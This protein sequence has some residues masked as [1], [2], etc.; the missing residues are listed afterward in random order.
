MHQCDVLILG[1]GPSGATAALT[2]RKAYPHLSVLMIEASDVQAVRPGEILDE[3]AFP[4]LKQL[5]LVDFFKD[6]KHPVIATAG[7]DYLRRAPMRL[8]D[9]APHKGWHLDRGRFDSMLSGFAAASGTAFF[10][11]SLQG[12]QLLADG[13]WQITAQS[14]AATQTAVARLVVDATGRHARFASE[15]GIPQLTYDSM[16][17][18]VRVIA[19]DDQT[20]A[21]NYA[22]MI[23]PFEHG[24]WYSTVTWNKQLAIV[25]MTDADIGK[26][27]QLTHITRWTEQLRESP[28]TYARV[29][30]LTIRGD[31]SIRAA[32][33]RGLHNCCGDGWLAVGDAASSFDPL[34]ENGITR[35]LR[36]GMQAAHAIGAHFS[37]KANAIKHY[38]AEIQ[39][40]FETN[41][42]RRTELYRLEPHWKNAAFWM[43]RQTTPPLPS[44]AQTRKTTL[45]ISNSMAVSAETP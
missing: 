31:L 17:G 23:E 44:K 12:V 13:R 14:A 39:S 3:D 32:N 10:R 38:Q 16:I 42:K 1:A 34:T 27:L 41:L 4:I 5:A 37:G 33:T 19:F 45:S 7:D 26:R 35:S 40:E 36:L 43:R 22:P 28:Q 15:I 18:I 2:L 30:D 11:G 9:L 20:Q 25:A 24:W 21:S 8:S 29:Q 6:Q